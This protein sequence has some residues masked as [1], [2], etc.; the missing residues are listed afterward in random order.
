M[1]IRGTNEIDQRAERQS[2]PTTQG[3]GGRVPAPDRHGPE[4]AQQ[5]VATGFEAR[6]HAALDHGDIRAA[7]QLVAE[8]EAETTPGAVAPSTIAAAKAHIAVADG[9]MPAARAILVV[10]IEAAPEVSYLRTL[11]TEVML[12]SGRATD[13]RPVL[14]HLGRAPSGGPGEATTPERPADRKI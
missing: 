5:P 9:D 6:L 1:A 12:A 4:S 14:T 3:G 2:A 11:L 13:V 7:R 8:T 10:A